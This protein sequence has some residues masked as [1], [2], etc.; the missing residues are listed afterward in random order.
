M[1]PMRTYIAK[2]NMAIFLTVAMVP[3]A[4][5]A[6]SKIAVR[7]EQPVKLFPLENVRLLE[8]PFSEAVKANRQYLLTHDPDRFLAPF[9]REAGLKPKAQPYG[10]WE[11]GG[12][13]G[14][15]AGHYL[16]A[17]SLMMASGA[18]PDGKFRR[19]LDYMIDELADIQK[20]NGNG[21]L[22]GIPKSEEYSKGVADGRVELM[23]RRW[24][25]WYDLHKV[26]AGLR[27]AYPLAGTR[28][29]DCTEE[30]CYTTAVR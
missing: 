28:D 10:N 13:D 14:H 5:A 2:M 16:S 25:P 23:Q 1:I 21:Y 19:R 29:L 12:L 3:S 18:N 20:V 22:G 11:N 15:A 17:L 24:A 8:S 4:S 30:A 6:A 26:F 7:P 27:D 9:R